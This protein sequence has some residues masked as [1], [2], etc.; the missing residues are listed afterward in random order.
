MPAVWAWTSDGAFGFA[1]ND[2]TFARTGPSF[3]RAPIRALTYLGANSRQWAT[4]FASLVPSPLSSGSGVAS[5]ADASG[6]LASEVLASDAGKQPLG[7]HVQLNALAPAHSFGSA[8]H[9]P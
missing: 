7:F 3:F 9:I 8:A 5:A 2:P 4:G 6:A 1:P